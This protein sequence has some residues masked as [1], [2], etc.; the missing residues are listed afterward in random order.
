MALTIGQ[1]AGLFPNLTGTFEDG[2]FDHSFAPRPVPDSEGDQA[3]IVKVYFDAGV[4]LPT[5]A[6]RAGWSDDEIVG[7]ENDLAKKAAEEET[8]LALQLVN[9]QRTFDQGN[10]QPVTNGVNQ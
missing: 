1:K 5:A 6:R 4:P 7:L 3:D 9:A 2:A 8:Q 10:Q